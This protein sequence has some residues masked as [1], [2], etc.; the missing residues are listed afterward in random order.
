MAAYGTR[1]SVKLEKEVAA[2]EGVSR[3]YANSMLASLTQLPRLG[4]ERSSRVM[5]REGVV[6][7]T[8]GTAP[9]SIARNVAHEVYEVVRSFLYANKLPCTRVDITIATIGI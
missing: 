3:I 8:I 6:A 4:E 7:V 5:M 1:M 9:G 2:I